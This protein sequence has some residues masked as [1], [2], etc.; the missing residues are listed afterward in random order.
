MAQ[1]HFEK[2]IETEK[3]GTAEQMFGVANGDSHRHAEL[4]GFRLGLIKALELF[5]KAT[6]TDLDEGAV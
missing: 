4:K 2:L 1:S 5:K 3:Q 6:K